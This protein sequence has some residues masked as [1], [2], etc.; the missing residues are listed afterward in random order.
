MNN[1]NLYMYVVDSGAL[2]ALGTNSVVLQ[3]ASDTNFIPRRIIATGNAGMKLQIAFNNS[4]QLSNISF[5][6]SLLN[7]TAN[8]GVPLIDTNIWPANSQLTFNF[9]NSNTG[10]SSL[11]EE[12]IIVG[13]KIPIS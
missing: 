9:I 13:E 6:T 10:G 1:P 8:A 4:E 7:N 11:N 3:L 5:N 2:A 12:V